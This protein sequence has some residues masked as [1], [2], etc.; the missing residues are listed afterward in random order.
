MIGRSIR[1]ATKNS[2]RSRSMIY[3][4]QPVNGARAYYLLAVLGWLDDHQALRFLE[5]LKQA[6]APG[7]SM[8]MI[9]D[10]VLSAQGTSWATTSSDRLY[11][12]C[13]APKQ[14]A[15]EE[16]NTLIKAAGFKLRKTY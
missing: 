15:E 16:F 4:Q 10:I 14:R 7:Y 3:G 8:V 5:Q 6:L 12:I 2:S 13:G 9:D 11:Y 1:P